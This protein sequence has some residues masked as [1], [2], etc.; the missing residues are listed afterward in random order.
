MKGF[1]KLII[2][3]AVVTVLAGTAI[4]A[5]MAGGSPIAVAR[6]FPTTGNTV[7][8]IITFTIENG[9]MHVKGSFSG[10]AP[11]KHGIHI[12]EFGDMTKEDGSSAGG[13]FNPDKK[14]HGGMDNPQRHEGDLGNIIADAKGNATIDVTDSLLSFAGGNS[15]LGRSV[16]IH[17]KEDDLATQPAGNSGSRIGY[18]VIGIAAPEKK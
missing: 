17:E 18:G 8:G 15:I 3:I 11:G 4:G 5:E 2:S 16:V 7:T 12:H 6:I 10:L 13:H 9:I 1:Q 14:M